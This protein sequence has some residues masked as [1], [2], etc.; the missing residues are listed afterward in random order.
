MVIT[1]TNAYAATA[2]VVDEFEITLRSGKSNSHQILRMLP[3]GL[4]VEVMEPDTGDG[5]TRVRAASGQDGWVLTRFLSDQPAAR[6]LLAQARQQLEALQA[7][8]LTNQLNVLKADF[9]ALTAE[10]DDLQKQRDA[11]NAARD[12]AE[13]AAARPLELAQENERYRTRVKQHQEMEQTLREENERLGSR[14][15]RDWFVAGGGV[16]VGGILLGLILPAL[17]PRRRKRWNEL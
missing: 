1:A 12:A 5:Y 13:D 16:L 3:S 11:A 8:D 7:G 4:A 17:R 6:E 2:Y 9:R 15:R 10:R 14:E